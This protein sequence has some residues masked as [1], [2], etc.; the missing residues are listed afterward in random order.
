[1]KEIRKLVE[2][3]YLQD[4]NM[5]QKALKTLLE[6]AET[7]KNIEDYLIIILYESLAKGK[8]EACSKTAAIVSG[9]ILEANP[10]RDMLTAIAEGINDQT[11]CQDPNWFNDVIFEDTD[12]EP[13]VRH[14]FWSKIGR[15]REV[16]ELFE[17][18]PY[19]CAID[20]RCVPVSP[21]PTID[22]LCDDDGESE[23]ASINSQYRPDP[24]PSDWKT[25]DTCASNDG[26]DTVDPTDNSSQTEPPTLTDKWPE[27]DTGEYFV[28]G[29]YVDYF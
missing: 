15:V 16:R 28:D 21:T 7:D 22:D 3:F 17:Q 6:M 20:E 2:G 27:G 9:L 29:D 25:D 11:V 26:T 13:E 10:H 23:S 24:V 18:A 1:M 4:L 14:A 19:S 8:L 12:I 5:I